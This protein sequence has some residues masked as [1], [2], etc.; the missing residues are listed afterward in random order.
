MIAYPLRKP[1]NFQQ[2][3]DVYSTECIQI[4]MLKKA[5]G[6]ISSFMFLLHTGYEKQ[7]CISGGVFSLFVFMDYIYGLYHRINIHTH[8]KLCIGREE[9]L[10]FFLIWTK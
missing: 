4:A 5:G 9:E 2:R 8:I 6:I 10:F 7:E 1:F 3:E